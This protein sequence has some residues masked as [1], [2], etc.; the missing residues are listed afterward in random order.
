MTAFGYLSMQAKLMVK[1]Q[2]PRPLD[3]KSVMAAMVQ[4]GGAGLMGDFLFGEYNRF[5]G[6]MASSLAGPFVGDVDQLRNLY[7]QARDGD[8]KAGDFLRF[9]INH[10]PFLNL[11]GVRQGMDYLILNRMQEWLSPGSLERYEQR[12]QKDQGN[13]FMLPPSQFMLGK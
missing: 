3:H 7:L 11:L 8:A 13:T 12:V 5:G 6:G 1:G 2:T 10:T 4:G 9:G